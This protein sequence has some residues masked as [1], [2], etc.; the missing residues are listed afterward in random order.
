MVNL[1][2]GERTEENY[3]TVTQV[4]CTL[5]HNEFSMAALKQSMHLELI[6]YFENYSYFFTFKKILFNPTESKRY[7]HHL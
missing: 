6:R 1:D 4:L 5:L 3:D 7:L 2:G